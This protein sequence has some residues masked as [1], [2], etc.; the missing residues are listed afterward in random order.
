MAAA[1]PG[2]RVSRWKRWGANVGGFVAVLLA[3]TGIVASFVGLW[4]D[5]NPEKRPDPRATVGAALSFFAIEPRVKLDDYLAR[6]KPKTDE[7][8]ELRAE[9]LRGQ[10]L[11]RIGLKQR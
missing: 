11:T 8:R 7:Y 6:A 2:D 5:F 4:Y 1:Q 10:A 9:H 3:L